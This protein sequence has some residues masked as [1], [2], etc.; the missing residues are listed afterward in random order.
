MIAVSPNAPSQWACGLRVLR[1]VRTLPP[2]YG[3]HGREPFVGFPA[4]YKSPPTGKG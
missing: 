3:H 1:Q 2:L 4:E